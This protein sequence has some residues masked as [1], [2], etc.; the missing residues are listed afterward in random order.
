MIYF[1]TSTFDD[2]VGKDL[3]SAN[4]SQI[5]VTNDLIYH[6][7]LPQNYFVLFF[8][9]KLTDRKEIK[10]LKVSKKK[11]TNKKTLK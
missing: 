9:E 1:L 6:H 10:K 8:K 4:F 5:K 7:A 3:Q 11:Q 2:G